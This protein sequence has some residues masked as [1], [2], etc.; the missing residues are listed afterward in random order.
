MSNYGKLNE[1]YKISE[2]FFSNKLF[3]SNVISKL[4][5]RKLSFLSFIVTLTRSYQIKIFL[6]II[7]F[8]INNFS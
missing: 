8:L 5:E 7:F 1:E 3:Y 2:L 4:K 6:K